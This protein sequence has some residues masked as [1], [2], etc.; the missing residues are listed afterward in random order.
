[1]IFCNKKSLRLQLFAFCF[2]F[3]IQSY[4]VN[5][6]IKDLGTLGGNL[7]S[8]SAINN[9]GTVVGM[10][11]NAS[12]KH[13]AFVYQNGTM[14]ELNTFDPTFSYASD[15]NDNGTIVGSSSTSFLFQNGV[16]SNIVGKGRATGVNINNQVIGFALGSLEP[17]YGY[18]YENGNIV[19]FRSLLNATSAV[20]SAINDHGQVVVMA[21]ASTYIY[22]NGAFTLLPFNGVSDIANNGQILCTNIG[23]DGKY[24]LC[25]YTDGVMQNLGDLNSLSTVA[26]S[27]NEKGYA[28]GKAILENIVTEP[29]QP[30]PAATSL[31]IFMLPDG[32]IS[33]LTS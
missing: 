29:F 17:G 19:N 8:A 22:H 23:A 33:T 21:D 12:M 14:T 15:I 5:F 10:S 3:S 2:L 24:D 30:A 13:A 4:A 27:V 28:V 26:Y 31:A 20:A 25:R 9:N 7:S 16:M 6:G 11:Q 32:T 18:L 1:M